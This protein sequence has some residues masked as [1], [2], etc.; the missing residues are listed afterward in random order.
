ML[1]SNNGSM[2]LVGDALERERRGKITGIL[3]NLKTKKG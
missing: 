3:E 1:V 2:I